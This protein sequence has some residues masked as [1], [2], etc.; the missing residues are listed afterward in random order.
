[1]VSFSIMQFRCQEY[2]D[3]LEVLAKNWLTNC[4]YPLP[5]GTDYPD[6]KDVVDVLKSGVNQADASFDLSAMYES[7]KNA[8]NYESNTC[9][10]SCANYRR[11]VWSTASQV[12]C[13]RHFC[14]RSDHWS[15]S[16]YIMA[17]LYRPVVLDKNERP[18]KNGTPC[19]E[20][21]FGPDCNHNQ[22]TQKQ[23]TATT[24][25]TSNSTISTMPTSPSS[26]TGS[27]KSTSPEQPTTS[28][29][30]Q[31]RAISHLIFAIVTLELIINLNR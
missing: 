1:M 15:E 2:S 19:S 9:T 6:Y 14:A 3:E 8:Y 17:C 26:S 23:T 31:L 27:S 4:T 13:Y 16:K 18:Y 22:C 10:S 29:S 5:N 12:G 11:M 28:V 30:S 25:T 24:P 20:C 7:E 21:P